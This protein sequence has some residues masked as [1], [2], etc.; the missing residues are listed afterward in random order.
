[1]RRPRVFARPI[2]ERSSAISRRTDVSGQHEERWQPPPFTQLDGPTS[3]ALTSLRRL[4]DVQA[5]TIWIDLAGEL[6]TLTGTLLD[7]GCGAQP[8]R[9]LVPRDVR[10]I[11]ID[12]ADAKDRFGYD[13][14][15]TTYFKGDHWPVEDAA[16]DAVLCTE[17]LE[18][19]LDPLSFLSEA[20]RALQPGGRLILTVPFSARWHYVPFD[21]WRF[22][23][24]GLAHIL[25]RSGFTEVEIYRRGNGLTVACYKATALML[26]LLM[27]REERGLRRATLRACGLALSPLLTASILISRLSLLYDG[28]DDCLG[29]T[30]LARRAA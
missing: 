20:K 11:G 24:S 18:H 27:P 17:T 4:L 9:T 7:V 14:P 26:P 22:T 10:Y 30:G 8:Y 3:H 29:Y 21:Y 1:M 25:N 6:K 28:G 12:T 5:S 19:V 13:V 15:D 16:V 23:P 2:S